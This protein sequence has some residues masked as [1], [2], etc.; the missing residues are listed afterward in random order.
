MSLPVTP[1]K[2]T[3]R[4]TLPEQGNVEQTARLL[5]S[6][7]D[8]SSEFHDGFHLIDCDQLR[9]THLCQFIAPPITKDLPIALPNRVGGARFMT[10]WLSSM[11]P[12]VAMT[13]VYGRIGE[14][15]LIRH[16]IVTKMLF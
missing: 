8:E 9:L 2:S 12:S 10:A 4:L 5:L 16:G 7:A 3:E 6:F 14:P 11:L 15:L 13:V 1:L